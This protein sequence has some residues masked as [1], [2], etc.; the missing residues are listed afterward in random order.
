MFL[1]LNQGYTEWTQAPNGFDNP[2]SVGDIHWAHSP[3][4]GTGCLSLRGRIY[5]HDIW[6]AWTADLGTKVQKVRQ[7]CG[8]RI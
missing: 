5:F 3:V 6:C 8:E 2:C 1:V 4:I 7:P